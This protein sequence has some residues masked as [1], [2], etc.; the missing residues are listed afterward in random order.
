MDNLTAMLDAL[1]AE[2][3]DIE[4]IEI[5]YNPLYGQEDALEQE[6]KRNGSVLAVTTLPQ[7]VNALDITLGVYE[8]VG[9]PFSE[10]NTLE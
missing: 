7:V 3:I 8:L 1:Q 4:D 10:Q 6:S 5:V 2:G 9:F